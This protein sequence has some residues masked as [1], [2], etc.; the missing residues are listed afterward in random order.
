MST[1]CNFI[2]K[3][4][5]VRNQGQYRIGQIFGRNHVY[6][7]HLNFYKQICYKFIITRDIN[8]C[9]PELNVDLYAC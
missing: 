4:K 3:R 9:S 1:P 7:R 6:L 2:H 8:L 5:W